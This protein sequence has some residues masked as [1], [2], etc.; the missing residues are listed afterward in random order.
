MSSGLLTHLKA[1]QQP[2]T[3]LLCRF[4]FERWLLHGHSPLRQARMLRMLE[5]LFGAAPSTA[6]GSS[7]PATSADRTSGADE[8]PPP[9]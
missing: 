9:P 7:T 8:Q 4:Q 1:H 3:C 6:H 2:V 5:S